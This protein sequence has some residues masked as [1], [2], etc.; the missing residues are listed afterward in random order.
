MKI[1]TDFVT[2]SSSSSFILARKGEMTEKQKE[3]VIKFV[4][5]EMLGTKWLT[6]DST[7][8][9]IQKAFDEE[10]VDEEYQEKV[11][12]ALKAGKTVYNGYVSFEGG[13][14]GMDILLEELW[15]KLEKADSENFEAIDG[16]LDY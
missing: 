2:N 3:A 15:E 12:A 16:S 6:P 10:Y 7:E 14:G 8:E 9:E 5:E 1:R 13:E 4:E 11:R